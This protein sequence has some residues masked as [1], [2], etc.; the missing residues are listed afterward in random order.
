LIAVERAAKQ[1]Y[2]QELERVGAHFKEVELKAEKR[3]EIAEMKAVEITKKAQELGAYVQELGV[4]S[5][6]LGE[7]MKEAGKQ[8]QKDS[9]VEQVQKTEYKEKLV[10]VHKEF[11]QSTKKN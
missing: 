8:T 1:K 5:K 10:D 4:E 3:E 9:K 6:N 7:Q 2:S 11:E